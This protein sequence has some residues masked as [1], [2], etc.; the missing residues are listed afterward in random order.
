[1]NRRPLV[2]GNWKMHGT[3]AFAGELSRAI[4]VG[5]AALPNVDIAICPPYLLLNAVA[6]ELTASSV[7]LGAQTVSEFDQ[8]AYTGETPAANLVAAGCHYVIVGHSE[9]RNIFGETDDAVAAKAR[10]AS[11]AGLTP[12]ICVGEKL[13]QRAEG[14][15][16]DV[17]SAQLAPFV[18]L[19]AAA[20]SSVV[21]AYEPVWAIGTGE[22][23]S[24]EQAQEVHA[25]IRASIG[26]VDA[27][28]ADSTRILYGG[29]VKPDNA[30]DLFNMVD[31]DGGL[32]GGASLN[33]EDFLRVCRSTQQQ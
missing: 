12:I 31:V 28:A 20:F 3:S 21:V 4:G 26:A 5:A 24:P 22:T 11:A 14:T 17:I 6:A 15:T 13:A 29:S 30:A 7:K 23:A 32:I 9:R 10:A 27:S 1:M 16:N 19:G 2:V 33:A 8:G 25:F 18:R